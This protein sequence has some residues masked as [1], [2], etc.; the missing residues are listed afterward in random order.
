ME[1]DDPITTPLFGDELIIPADD[2]QYS[3]FIVDRINDPSGTASSVGETPSS[4]IFSDGS[5]AKE[6]PQESVSSHDSSM[7]SRDTNNIYS[8]KWKNGQKKINDDKDPKNLD[9]SKGDGVKYKK[10]RSYFYN[11]LLY[12]KRNID[13][14]Y[15]YKYFKSYFHDHR[16]LIS[17]NE[18][19]CPR[20][21]IHNTNC[22]WYNP[23][24]IYILDTK[25]DLSI[26]QQAGQQKIY[27][28][29]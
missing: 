22:P 15:Y 25:G 21:K 9:E 24:I 27:Q 1:A 6:D 5:K 16:L 13:K 19:Q 8:Q 18:C 20:G 28:M 26:S 10:S 23:D 17:D 2:P 4:A 3:T 11:L 7:H 12:Y 14:S 29:Y